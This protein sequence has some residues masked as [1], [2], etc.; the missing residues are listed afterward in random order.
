M[1][2]KSNL[3]ALSVIPPRSR[4][5][6]L[7]DTLLGHIRERELRPGDRLGTLDEIRD[8]VGF[9]RTTVSE[10][11][12][13]LRERGVLEIRP[14]RGGGLFI[15]AETPVVR[16][17]HTLLSA[18][19]TASSVRDAIGLREALEEPIAIGAAESCTPVAAAELRAAVAA[20]SEPG[21]GYE[22]FI[23]RNWH[24]H[25]LIAGLAP[26]TMM[27]AVYIS[28]LGYLERSEPAY[29]DTD[30]EAAYIA[31]RAAAHRELVEAVV[32]GDAQR[33]RRAVRSHNHPDDEEPR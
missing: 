12:R 5:E 8:E 25:E 7:A 32:A 3:E 31:D 30:R 1:T 28:C 6:Q 23:R 33:I 10:S 11:V 26:N 15:A 2:G 21:I 27:S 4:A 9:A 22:E 18:Q 14:G 20:M 19:G 24:L 13:L 16:M 17:R 29:G